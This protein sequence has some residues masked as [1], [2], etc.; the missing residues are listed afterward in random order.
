[1]YGDLHSAIVKSI[2]LGVCSNEGTCPVAAGT[3]AYNLNNLLNTEHLINDAGINPIKHIKNFIVENAVWICLVDLLLNCF[4]FIIFM[5]SIATILFQEGISGL[6]AVLYVL[7]CSAKITSERVV[8]KARK[9]KVEDYPLYPV[10][11][12]ERPM[13]NHPLYPIA[14]ETET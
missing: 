14:E 10:P 7:F 12:A 2:S 3:P 13:E 8:R 11:K 1:M 9:R 5:T 6:L 4:K